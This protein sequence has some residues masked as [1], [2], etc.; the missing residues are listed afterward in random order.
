MFRA[1]ELRA[2]AR[3]E[4]QFAPVG[5]SELQADRLVDCAETVCARLAQ[6]CWAVENVADETEAFLAWTVVAAARAGGEL[7]NGRVGGLGNVEGEDARLVSTYFQNERTEEQCVTKLFNEHILPAVEE[8]AKVCQEM[9]EKPCADI[10]AQLVVHNG[11]AVPL[12][13]AV[14]ATG[15]RCSAGMMKDKAE[16]PVVQ[17]RLVT[18]DGML[19]TVKHDFA[20]ESWALATCGLLD[21]GLFLYDVAAIDDVTVVFIAGEPPMGDIGDGEEKVSGELAVH[22]VVLEENCWD[23]VHVDAGESTRLVSLPEPVQLGG[24]EDRA[25][26]GG[27]LKWEKS[28]SLSLDEDRKVARYVYRICPYAIRLECFV[29][30]R[31]PTNSLCDAIYLLFSICSVLHSLKRVLL[32]QLRST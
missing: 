21:E 31:S 24:Y 4:A 3:M 9:A 28:V 5:L 22:H 15:R 11:I 20:D 27:E 19:L 13:G 1:A 25:T 12:A 10:S 8:L 6:F 14:P 18:G 16:S 23:V 17:A 29:L 30:Y 2:L 32:F 26:E 7:V